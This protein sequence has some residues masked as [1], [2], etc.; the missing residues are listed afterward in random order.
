MGV[1][2][3][4]RKKKKTDKSDFNP[5]TSDSKLTGKKTFIYFKRFRRNSKYL[6]NDDD[7]V[8]KLDSIIRKC[9][10]GDFKA[11][12]EGILKAGNARVLDIGYVNFLFFFIFIIIFFFHLS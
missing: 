1:T 3:S 4:K 6:S 8:D 9:W 7:E 2:A 10:D 11:P 12:V 5:S